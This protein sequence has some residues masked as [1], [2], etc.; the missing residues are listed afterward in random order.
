MI[1]KFVLLFFITINLFAQWKGFET[2]P[3]H[4]QYNG[5]PNYFLIRD[6]DNDGKVD[7]I[8]GTNTIYRDSSGMLVP[9]TSIFY[10]VLQGNSNGTFQPEQIFPHT[11]NTN[12]VFSNGLMYDIADINNDGKM[13]VISSGG[14]GLAIF[15]GIDP[16]GA[17][18]DTF[19]FTDTCNNIQVLRCVDINN[20]GYQDIILTFNEAQS[21]FSS[22]LRIYYNN[23]DNTFTRVSHP[24]VGGGVGWIQ[25]TDFDNDG[26][27]D[28]LK[29]SGHWYKQETNGVFTK[30]TYL[31]GFNSN[32]GDFNNDGI[33][34][35]VSQ[36]RFTDTVKVQ[37]G[38]GVGDF[39]SSLISTKTNLNLGEI[40]PQ[41]G[42]FNNDGKLD[43]FVAT[44]F[45]PLKGIIS[46][47]LW[48]LLGNGNGTFQNPIPVKLGI[49]TLT[50]FQV[51]DINNDN[52]Q[53]IIATRFTEVY[54]KNQIAI[55]LNKGN[56]IT[57]IKRELINI[58][59]NYTLQQNYPNPFNPTTEIQFQ[60]P[61]NE[62][63]ILK[64]Y[65]ILGKEIT[66][67]LNQE[68]QAGAYQIPFNASSLTSG[69]YY[70]R[71]TAGKFSET[72]K[73]IMIK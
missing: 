19:F 24:D 9:Q 33:P 7:I 56:T 45:T 18:A 73:M 68:M 27:I 34:D 72:K 51:A 49:D 14:N 52:Y 65:N 29:G 3:T 60:I 8:G 2:T 54:T 44:T 16:V 53:D 58:P 1:K 62:K 50:S 30:K 57:T 5:Y 61:T 37:F 35:L 32:I 20:D 25:F 17:I 42:D 69:I 71:L 43:I 31:I 66:T 4:Y 15:M 23:H 70:Y 22:A 11:V 41:V 38:T 59:E 26:R 36:I 10:N 13:D 6:Y 12:F 28:I 21:Q 63:V 48:Y 46:D 64:V 55:V 67:L 39:S 40:Q 47:T